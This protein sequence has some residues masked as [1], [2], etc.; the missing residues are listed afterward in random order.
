MVRFNSTLRPRPQRDGLT[1]F[2]TTRFLSRPKRWNHQFIQQ[3]MIPSH[4]GMKKEVRGFVNRK[5]VW[6][7]SSLVYQKNFFLIPKNRMDYRDLEIIQILMGKV[8]VDSSFLLFKDN[9]IMKKCSLNRVKTLFMQKQKFHQ[10]ICHS[11]LCFVDQRLSVTPPAEKKIKEGN[12]MRV[13]RTIQRYVLLT[14]SFLWQMIAPIKG[15]ELV[16][17]V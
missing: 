11:P 5:N 12:L 9:K 2:F 1:R 13:L 14:I 17:H 6:L 15:R 3:A 8:L 4:R 7:K 10:M 16:L